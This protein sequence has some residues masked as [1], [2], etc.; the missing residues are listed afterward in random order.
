VVA[1]PNP[2]LQFKPGM[3][4]QVTFVTARH[5]AV[6]VVPNAAFRVHLDSVAGA[7]GERPDRADRRSLSGPA[8]T[9]GAGAADAK[10]GDAPESRQ[11]LWVLRDGRPEQR[12]VQV[13]H[14]DGE[15]TEIVTGL[16]AGEPVIIGHTTS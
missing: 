11:W 3:T 15:R 4:A 8:S 5:E 9:S 12:R 14:T 13:G 2:A 16:Q 10:H 7:G 6:L 1:A